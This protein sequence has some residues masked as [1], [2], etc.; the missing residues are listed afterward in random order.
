MASKDKRLVKPKRGPLPPILGKGSSH[1]VKTKYKRKD[2]HV[3][4]DGIDS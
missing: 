3:Y 2:K 4:T 1:R